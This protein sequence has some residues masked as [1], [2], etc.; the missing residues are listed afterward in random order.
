[1]IPLSATFRRAEG[2]CFRVNLCTGLNQVTVVARRHGGDTRVEIDLEQL[3]LLSQLSSWRSAEEIG[4][5]HESLT[6]LVRANLAFW[7]ARRPKRDLTSAF[8]K[9]YSRASL[10]RNVAHR[11]LVLLETGKLSGIDAMPRRG[12]LDKARLAGV[13]LTLCEMEEE[14]L[15][16]EFICCERHAASLRSLIPLLD[17]RHDVRELLTVP[18]TA[19]LLRVLNLLGMIENYEAPALASG[20]FVTW[21]G[22]AAVLYEVEGRR[23]L[24]DPLLLSQSTP[25]RYNETPPDPRTWGPVDAVLITH[26]DNDHLSPNSLLR[27]PV[28]TLMVIP[29]TPEKR[30]YQVD[31]RRLLE[32]LGFTR[33]CELDEWQRLSIGGVTV[34]AVPF[35]GEDWGMTLSCRTYVLSSQNLTVFL[36]ADSVSDES[37]YDRIAAEFDIDI[38]FLGVS[39]A[40]EAYAMPPPYGYGGFYF[41]WLPEER[42]NEWIVL[43]NGPEEAAAAAQQLRARYAFGYAAGGVTSYLLAYSDRGTHEE[44]ASFLREQQT[45]EGRKTEPIEMPLGVAVRFPRPPNV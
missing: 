11:P 20:S 21:L 32:V 4:V 43:C 8:L 6:G 1:M 36:N 27:L 23:I 44:M 45:S 30:D 41:P 15:A 38:A 5:P 29:S 34:V 42:H 22:H 9:S 17:G 16:A 18:D 7:S 13:V 3:T 37:A 35:L 31:M 12:T 28:D 25:T 40:A 39:G 26:G 33:I 14:V 2:L 10:R 19:D 24:V